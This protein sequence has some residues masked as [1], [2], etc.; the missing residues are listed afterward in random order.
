MRA[1]QISAQGG[2]P[3]SSSA[4]ASPSTPVASQL[5]GKEIVKVVFVPG[6]LVNFVVK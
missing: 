1:K 5:A 3:P 2:Q 6:R 4:S